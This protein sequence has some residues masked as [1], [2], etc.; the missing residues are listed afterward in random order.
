VVITKNFTW[1]SF[2]IIEAFK[3]IVIV[4]YLAVIIANGFARNFIAI[5]MVAKFGCGLA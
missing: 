4:K 2:T 3:I 1:C 5:K